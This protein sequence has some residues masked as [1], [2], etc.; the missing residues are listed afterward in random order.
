MAPFERQVWSAVIP[1][2]D[3]TLEVRRLIYTTNPIETLNS[4]ICRAIRIRGHVPSD[5]PAAKLIYLTLQ[6][7]SKEWTRYASNWP[8]VNSQF[9]FVFEDRF[10]IR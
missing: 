6:A 2:L 7:T 8:A 10:P 5:Q 9:A 3:F 4:A 1:F